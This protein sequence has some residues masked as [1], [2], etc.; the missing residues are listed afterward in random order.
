[1]AFTY[2][3]RDSDPLALAIDEAMPSLQGRA[4]IHI[5]DAGCAHGPEPYTLAILLRERMSQFVFRNVRIH[6]TDLDVGFATQVRSGVFRADEIRRVPRDIVKRYFSAGMEPGTVVT[7]SEL[8]ARIEFA[9]HDLLSLQPIRDG[10]SLIVCKNVLL[11]FSELQRVHVLTM[12]HRALQ[13]G[14]LIVME[15]TQRLPEPLDPYFQQVTSCAR[16]YRKVEQTVNVP[17]V[18]DCRPHT[19]GRPHIQLPTDETVPSTNE[20][21]VGL[22]RP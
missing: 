21:R 17:A 15:H 16:I 14:G 11:H 6:A 4:F 5:W 10:L 12:F 8:R 18:G 7:A 9:Q 1:M 22:I 13:P 2:F 20:R 3:F 19:L